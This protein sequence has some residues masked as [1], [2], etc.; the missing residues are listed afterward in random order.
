[1]LGFDVRN[2]PESCIRWGLCVVTGLAAKMAKCTPVRDAWV[3]GAK[4]LNKFSKNDRKTNP[5]ITQ[6][7]RCRRLGPQATCKGP[8]GPDKALD[9]GIIRPSRN[10][11]FCFCGPPSTVYIHDALHRNASQQ[12]V[13]SALVKTTTSGKS[14]LVRRTENTIWLACR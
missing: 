4:Q 14:V 9:G 12:F 10:C 6:N 5:R 7:E 2:L 13:Q 3:R 11:L 8:Q 1:M